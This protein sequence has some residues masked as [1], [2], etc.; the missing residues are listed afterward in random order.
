MQINALELLVFINSSQKLAS[1]LE[2]L[3]HP[4]N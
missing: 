3:Q 2:N 1:L 4:A